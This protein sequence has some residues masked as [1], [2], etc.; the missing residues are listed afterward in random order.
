[1]LC[2]GAPAHTTLQSKTYDIK[3]YPLYTPYRYC[4]LS[5]SFAYCLSPIPYCLLPVAYVQMPDAYRLLPIAYCLLPIAYCMFI[6][7]KLQKD[8]IG[9]AA[10][11]AALAEEISTEVL[12][13]QAEKRFRCASLQNA[14][15]HGQ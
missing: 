13:A 2:F 6:R 15:G 12:M 5:I 10:I 7:E 3:D 11:I 4:L 8:H 1:M 14:I 9:S